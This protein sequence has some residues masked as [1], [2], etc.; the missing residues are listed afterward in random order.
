MSSKGM[1]SGSP[2]TLWWVLM[3]AEGPP[4]LNG[5]DDVGVEGPLHQ[6]AGAVSASREVRSKTSMKVFPIRF[7]FSSGSSTPA[8]APRNSSAASTTMRRIPMCFRKVRST[9]L[10]LPLPQHA[11]VHEDAG[12]A[13]ADGPV[14]QRRRYRGV[15][16]ARQPADGGPVA[17]LRPDGLHRLRR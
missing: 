14:H 2:P 16:A 6:E 11:V 5:L 17:H 3:V 10:P 9:A 4:V 8:S 13:V 7:R 12:Q 1:S 15:H